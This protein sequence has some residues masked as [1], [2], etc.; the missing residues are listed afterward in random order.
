MRFFNTVVGLSFLYRALTFA[1]NSQVIT[2]TN[3]Q[4]F[5]TSNLIPIPSRT[6]AP[7]SSTEMGLIK[8]VANEAKAV[9]TITE[10][11]VCSLFE[12]WNSALTTGDSCIVA[13]H[14]A[15][16]PV[17]LTTM[18]DQPCTDFASVNED[19]NLCLLKK[20]QGK[21]LDK[22][23]HIGDGWASD[24][25]I[26]EFTM[27]ATGDKIKV[28]YIYNYIKGKHWNVSFSSWM[29]ITEWYFLWLICW[30]IFDQTLA[31]DEIW[32]I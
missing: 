20:L 18:N 27:G 6:S 26:Y 7:I 12:L 4:A 2:S 3:S 1:P 24:M 9:E 11:E 13:N 14:F 17:L 21:I 8:Q 29:E 28:H 5:V 23:I 10:M 32:K 15:K 22:N 30:P 25:H 31:E 16:N 19:F